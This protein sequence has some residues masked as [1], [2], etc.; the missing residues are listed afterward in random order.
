MTDL[1]LVSIDDMVDEI[2]R[3]SDCMVIAV[4]TVEDKFDPIVSCKYGDDFLKAIGMCEQIK[5]V[6]YHNEYGE[7]EE[8]ED[9]D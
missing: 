7:D 9:E 5:K 1:S 6:I 2:K 3:R 8:A 4:L